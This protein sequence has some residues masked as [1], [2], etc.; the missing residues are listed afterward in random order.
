MHPHHATRFIGILGRSR[1]GKDTVAGVFLG[2][3]SPNAVLERLSQPL[4]DAA[5]ALYGFREE[6]IEGHDK[7]KID[8]RYGITPRI[9]IQDLGEHMMRTHGDRFF[10]TRLYARVPLVRYVI[11]PDVRYAH[12]I[13]EIHRRGGVVVKVTRPL[14]PQVPMHAWESPIENMRGDICI[15]NT[16]CL[17]RLHHEAYMAWLEIISRNGGST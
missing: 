16:G 3:A 4:K 8:P 14:H 9:A 1:V 7:E 17:E 11:I 5:R 2:L 6:Q 12:D 15:H 13:E 10:S